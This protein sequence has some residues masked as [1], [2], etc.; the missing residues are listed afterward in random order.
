MVYE[1]PEKN[2]CKFHASKYYRRILR[3]KNLILHA[4]QEKLLTVEN[5]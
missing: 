3:S 2:H 5:K 1:S 4:L